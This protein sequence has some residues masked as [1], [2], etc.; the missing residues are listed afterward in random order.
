M[1]KTC[2]VLISVI[3]LV[4]VLLSVSIAGEDHKEDHK[5]KKEIKIQQKPENLL[6]GVTHAMSYSEYRRGQHPDVGK[7]ANYPSE[8][9]ILEDLKILT[10]DSNFKLIRLYNSGVS[11]EKVLKVIR[12]NKIDIK[13][14][15]GA[16]LGAEVSNHE[17]CAWLNEPIPQDY[18]DTVKGWNK[19]E[20]KNTIRLANE[21]KD[22]VVAVNVGNE[23]LIGWT[24]HLVPVESMIAYVKE[25]KKAIKQPITVADNYGWWVGEG[26]KLADEV[27]F[28]VVHL[29]PLWEGRDI[30][31]GM[32]Y[33]I[34]NIQKVR[35]KLPDS[36]I[37]IGEI[38]WAT[39]GSEFGDRASEEKQ[40]RFYNELYTWTTK[41]NI[42]T[43]WFSAF[44]EDW[45]GDP[46]NMQAAEK[47]W[48]IFDIDRKPKLVMHEKYPDLVPKKKE[49]KKKD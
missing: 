20:I 23:A 13:I 2:K 18:L 15:L 21:Y 7:G 32:S 35:D 17:G 36:K 33:T 47:H 39:I 37:V 38:G 45:K 48:G 49:E 3:I 5:E 34:E 30:D 44:D 28:V 16:W 14:M 31:Q 41:M 25:V 10:R 29:Y 26:E 46:G 40:K 11:T 12:E 27:D 22:I 42:T 24:D 8:A 19:T 43:F 9:E 1:N 6:L 4:C